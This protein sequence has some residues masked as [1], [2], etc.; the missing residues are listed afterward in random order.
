VRETDVDV[1]RVIEQAESLDGTASL[2]SLRRPWTIAVDRAI[3]WLVEPLA[4]ALVAI[5]VIIL[6]SSVFFRYVMHNALVWSDELAMIFFLWFSMLGAVSAMRRGTHMRLSIVASKSGPE[7]RKWFDAI[8]CVA[9]ALFCL[10]MIV[11]S[12][13]V[14]LIE[15]TDLTPALGI[16]RSWMVAPIIVAMVLIMVLAILRLIDS[17]PKVVAGVVATSL[18]LIAIAY[19]GRGV[20]S[21]LGNFNLILFFVV[22]V[23]AL[24]AIGVPIAFCFGVGTL[25]FLALTTTIPLPVVIN[26]MDGGISNDVLIAVP[27][28]VLLGG[29]MT[30]AGIGTRLVQA[31]ASVVGHVRG[32]LNVVL[33]FAMYLVSG[34]SGS[35][36]ADMA[37]VAP[38]LFPEMK[39]R[40]IPLGELVALLNA[41]VSM[42]ETIPPALILIIVGSV[43]GVSIAALFTAGL[44]P[45][46]V[47]ALFLLVVTLLRARNDRAELAERPQLRRILKYFWIAIPGFALPFL[48]RF[49]VLG[50]VATA[51]EVSTVGIL[52]TLIVGA[53][54]YRELNWR[55]VYSALRETVPLTGAIM[56]IIATATA[57][58]WALT[59]S[60]FA[61]QLAAA[62]AKA[63]GG[64]AMFLALSSLL[65]IVL[66]SALEGIP[67]IVLFGPVLFPIAKANG[68]DEI[69]YAIV[70][71]LAM[72]IGL[73]SPPVGIGYYIAC[74]IGKASPDEAMTR[75]WPNMAPIVLALICVAAIPWLTLG[76]LPKAH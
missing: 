14:Y 73:H 34:I 37:A 3:G 56:L 65:F 31:I 43:T 75:T 10:E 4:A 1:E 32:G 33:I 68:I 60:G 40:G 71:I 30:G 52:Y 29:L 35:K 2:G 11:A 62:V 58:T 24:V 49:L 15:M 18:A 28:F 19:A 5:D 59:Q 12:K 47:A 25:S 76:F 8:A 7:K 22:F 6:G 38:V 67:A 48:I 63:P 42:S 13:Q 46:A 54:I 57:M 45:A 26:R 16:P 72:G 55:R 20:F 69:Q 51:T 17:D 39:R 53:F 41:S 74:T 9:V 50:G 44:V 66:G 70:S 23:G 21:T 36:T 61:D 27:L 64:T